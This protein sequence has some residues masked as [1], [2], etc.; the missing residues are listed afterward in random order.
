MSGLVAARLG[1]APLTVWFEAAWLMMTPKNGDERD[2]PTTRAWDRQLPD[3]M[4]ML[5]RYRDGMVVPSRDKLSGEVDVDETFVGG[6]H[7]AGQSWPTRDGRRTVT[8]LA[9]ANP[10]H[11]AGHGLVS[12]CAGT[13]RVLET[14]IGA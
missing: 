1:R 11:Y 3:G 9:M 8:R 5:H 10:R 6:M 4:A 14:V 13:V 2:E 12:R 7:G